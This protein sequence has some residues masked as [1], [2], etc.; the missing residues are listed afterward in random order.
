M[1][2][3]FQQ[4]LLAWYQEHKRDLSFRKNKEAYQIW[5]SEIMAQ[6]T[7]IEAMLDYHSRFV[8]ELPTMKDL[9]MCDDEK[10]HKLWQ[11]LGYYSRVKNL[12]KCAQVCMADYGGQLPQTKKELMKLPGIG[13]YTAGAIA[14]IA[15][16]ENVSAVDGNVIRVFSRLFYVTEDVNKTSTKKEIEQL[17]ETSLPGSAWISDYNQALMELGALVCIPKNP[18][19]EQCPIQCHCLGFQHQDVKRLPIQTKK[20]TRKIEQKDIY[21]LV[22]EDQ[23]H[24]QKRKS[25]GLLADLYGFDE[26]KPCEDQI[27]GMRPLQPYTHIFTHVE[28]HMN[29]SCIYVS[30]KHDDQ[31][32]TLSQIHETIAIPSAFMPFLEEIERENYICQKSL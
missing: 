9:A 30:Q 22:Y 13:A 17:V 4:D 26:E 12:K 18:R 2:M 31:F 11:G 6:Q 16:D 5:I 1:K 32:F 15:F 24:I 25:T 20:K 8:K 3:N 29:A 23:I 10:L 27:L 28:W 21:I 19:C 14:S 7:R